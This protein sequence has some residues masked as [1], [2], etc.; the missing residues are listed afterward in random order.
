[1]DV[2][3]VVRRYPAVVDHLKHTTTDDVLSG[4]TQLEGGPEARDVIQAFLAKYGMRCPGEIDVTRP[5][6]SEKP[7][8]L[9]PLI[10]GN[11]KSFAPR[12]GRRKIEQGRQEALEKEQDLLERLERLPDGERKVAETKQMIDV[13]RR[14][15]GYREYPKYS[16]VNRYFVYKQAML[17]EA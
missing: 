5:R 16:I 10:L 2:A 7:S 11:V 6:W 13:V 4:L 12:A 1:L 3:D 8:M 9:V 14:F 17:K 15:M